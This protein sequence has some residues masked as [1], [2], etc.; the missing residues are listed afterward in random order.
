VTQLKGC[1]EITEIQKVIFSV[2]I[3]SLIHLFKVN[4][5]TLII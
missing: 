4:V 1:V 3:Y 2:F 5:N